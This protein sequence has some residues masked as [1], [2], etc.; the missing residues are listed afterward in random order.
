MESRRKRYKLKKDLP[1]FK[2]GDEFG[3]GP[4]GD[5]W[6]I[7][8]YDENGDWDCHIVAY[9]KRTL[10]EFP[11]ILKDW[12]EEIPEEHDACWEPKVGDEYWIFYINHESHL[13]VRQFTCMDEHEQRLL[14]NKAYPSVSAARLAGEKELARRKA[15][16]ILER[17]TKGFKPDVY[18]LGQNRFYVSYDPLSRELCW[19][20]ERNDDV[21]HQITFA[22]KE[23]A[24]ASI[25]AHEKEW[26]CYLNIDEGE[27]K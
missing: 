13:C 17:D 2:A 7:D 1:T 12:F 8:G 26:L 16:V 9:L 21:S 5:L 20:R 27:E 23:D 10:E 11:N 6:K 19:I 22:T 18:N 14:A 15:K 25:K 24:E 4:G 3:I